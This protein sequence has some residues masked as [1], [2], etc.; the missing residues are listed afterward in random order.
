MIHLLIGILI[1]YL[2]RTIQWLSDDYQRSKDIYHDQP[3]MVARFG[4]FCWYYFSNPVRPLLRF[5]R[6]SI[7]GI[8]CEECK[9][10][11][12]GDSHS[13]FSGQCPECYWGKVLERARRD[14][15]ATNGRL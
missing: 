13:D 3:W 15:G 1:G 12:P 4:K 6:N 7:L 11:L 5:I 8:K 9:R 14:Q 10:T 2:L